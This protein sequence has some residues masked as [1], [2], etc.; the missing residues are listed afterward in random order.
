[1]IQ[2]KLQSWIGPANLDFHPVVVAV[3]LILGPPVSSDEIVLGDEVPGDGETVH[4][5]PQSV[6]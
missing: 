4:G 6:E 5:L 1:L 3:E 2:L